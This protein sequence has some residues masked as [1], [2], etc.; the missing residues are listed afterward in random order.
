MGLAGLGRV[1]GQ[2]VS[3]LQDYWHTHGQQLLT[4]CVGLNALEVDIPL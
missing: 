3:S 2:E 4:G 1:Q